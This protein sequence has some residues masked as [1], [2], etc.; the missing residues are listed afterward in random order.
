MQSFDQMTGGAMEEQ[1]GEKTRVLFNVV[2]AISTD[3]I[4]MLNNTV[5]SGKFQ[6]DC[7]LRI[8]LTELSY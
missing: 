8:H 1:R 6:C 4:S 3:D 2:A 5:N 7:N